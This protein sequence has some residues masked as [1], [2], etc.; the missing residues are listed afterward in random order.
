MADD[1]RKSDPERAD[2]S[3]AELTARLRAL[4]KRL[5]TRTQERAEADREK[6]GNPGFAAALR[7]SSEF[8]AAILVGVAIGWAIDRFFGVSP[9][10]MIGFLLLGFCAGVLNVLRSAGLMKQPEDKA[11]K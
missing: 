11:G 9:W 5:G 7:L 1:D 8:V 10:G 4:E 3:E 6:P 2:P